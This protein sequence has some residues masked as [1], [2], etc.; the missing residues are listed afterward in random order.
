MGN[1][2]FYNGRFYSEFNLVG[3]YRLFAYSLVAVSYSTGLIS[4][5]I[6]IA[7][8]IHQL[9]LILFCLAHD[10]SLNAYDWNSPE[11]LLEMVHDLI[12][13]LCFILE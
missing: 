5:I 11:L 6:S 2:I 8:S 10:D 9:S 1:D 7:F 3:I 12:Q 4:F 13:L